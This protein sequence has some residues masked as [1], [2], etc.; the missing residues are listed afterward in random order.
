MK[1][2]KLKAGMIVEIY[3]NYKDLKDYQGEAELIEK[4]REGLTFYL[5]TDEDMLPGELRPIYSYEM[6]IVKFTTGDRIGLKALRGIRKLVVP[7]SKNNKSIVATYDYNTR[8]KINMLEDEDGDMDPD[9]LA[10][11][12]NEGD[13]IF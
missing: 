13:F 4:K 6:W 9:T 12:P 7:I 3:T 2:D 1:K 11:L 5:S 8:N 10:S